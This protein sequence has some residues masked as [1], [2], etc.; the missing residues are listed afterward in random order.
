[1]LGE[2]SRNKILESRSELESKVESPIIINP[3]KFEVLATKYNPVPEQCDSDPLITADNSKIDL[4]MLSK[5][6]LRWIAVSRD[7]LSI[8]NYGDTITVHS[9]NHKLNGDWI[10]H[11]TMNKRF[12]NRIDFLVP[13]NDNYDFHKPIKLLICKKYE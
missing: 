9:D 11:D 12:T 5:H 13:L 8:F 2:Y 4:D 7:L 1:M 10:I 3:I 6:N